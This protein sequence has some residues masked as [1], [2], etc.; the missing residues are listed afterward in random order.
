MRIPEKDRANDQ[1]K[2]LE[3]F[4]WTHTQDPKHKN[5]WVPRQQQS[6]DCHHNNYGYSS[7]HGNRS[8]KCGRSLL[9]DLYSDYSY[10]NRRRCSYRC[11]NS[12]MRSPPHH[13][14]Y[15]KFRSEERSDFGVED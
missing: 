1:E 7:C 10:N 8:D 9:S 5:S 11:H 3:S 6:G 14:N 13:R 12:H 2:Y 15:Y 4:V